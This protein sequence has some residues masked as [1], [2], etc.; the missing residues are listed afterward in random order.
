MQF[1]SLLA[2][3]QIQLVNPMST[4]PVPIAPVNQKFSFTMD[5][6]TFKSN[7]TYSLKLLNGPSWI[8]FDPNSL[9]FSGTPPSI[10]T[11][12]VVVKA[13]TDTQ[14]N[15]DHLVV[16][17][18]SN[19][20]AAAPQLQVQNEVVITAN[21]FISLNLLKTPATSFGVRAFAN[22]LQLPSVEGT[23]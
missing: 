14:N 20:L 18:V 2:F 19:G 17:S 15:V 11:Y 10:G 4:Q 5:S 22:K 6:S 12:D 8:Q 7:S 9:T 3:G 23:A 16:K 13:F 1:L 21:Q